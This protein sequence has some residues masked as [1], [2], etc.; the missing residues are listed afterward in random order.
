[1]HVFILQ[2]RSQK[3][4]LPTSKDVVPTSKDVVV[5]AVFYDG[6]ARNG[7]QNASVFLIALKKNIMRNNLVVKCGV[8]NTT[9]DKL[10]V[11]I[12]GE[13]PFRDQGIDARYLTHEEIMLDCFDLSVKNGSRA[14]VIYKRQVDDIELIMA[15]SE[16]PLIFPAPH[17]PPPQGGKYKFTVLTCGKLFGKSPP[18]MKEWLRYQKTLGVDHVHWNVK[19]S[20]IKSKALEN[21]YIK[22]AMEDGYLSVN[23]WKQRFQSNEIWYY[24]QGLMYEDCIYRFRGTYDYIFMLDTDDFFTPRI[25][26]ETDIHYYINLC[27]KQS[28]IGSCEFWWIEYYPDKCGIKEGPLPKDGNVTNWLLSYE[29]HT[30]MGHHKSLHKSEAILDAATHFA[31]ELV[32]GYLKMSTFSKHIAYVAHVRKSKRL[33]GKC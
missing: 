14:F 22:K 30:V 20:I 31:A 1:M 28:N 18:W 7:H 13:A 29:I 33:K 17:K 26:N 23:V 6:R 5:R 27:T 12:I 3:R 19:D 11:R 16:Q 8:E 25:S 9:T 4:Y 10:H 24:S 15:E 21:P 32:P 2:G